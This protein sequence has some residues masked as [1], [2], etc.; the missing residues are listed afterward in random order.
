MNAHAA[1]NGG[2]ALSGEDAR[3]LLNDDSFGAPKSLV[4]NPAA[5]EQASGA[6]SEEGNAD[7]DSLLNARA[8]QEDYMSD[9]D[10]DR[11]YIKDI[12]D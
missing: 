7:V 2:N 6:G 10:E 3:K 12:Q 8:S 11:K 4:S 5:A 1:V 9:I